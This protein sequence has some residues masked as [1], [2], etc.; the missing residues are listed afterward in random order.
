MLSRCF[1]FESW[2]STGVL[3]YTDAA[4]ISS[5]AMNAV[6]VMTERGYLSW[7]GTEFQPNK[8][9]TRAEIMATLDGAI[10][11]I[12]TSNGFYSTVVEGSAL[13]RASK[14]YLMNCNI[15]GNVIIP[16]NAE[17]VVVEELHPELVPGLNRGV[18]TERFVFA[19]KVRDSGRNDEHFVS[20]DAAPLNAREELLRQN[21]D[22]RRRQLRAD[23][24]LLVR[25]ENVDDTV[26]RPLRPGGVERAE[27][28]VPRFGGG[29][30][31]FDRF[32]VAHFPDEDDVR[33][34]TQ[35]AADRVGEGHNVDADFALVDGRLFMIVVE[36]DR[37]FDRDDVVVDVRVQPVDASGERRR[38]PGTGRAGN[39]NHAARTL[40]QLFHDGR[41]P[42]LLHR[43][44][45]VRN[46][47]QNHPGVP[48]L[49]EDG[50]AETGF[51]A[52]RE[53]EVGAA[54][55][56]QFLLAAARRDTFHQRNGVGRLERFRFQ[57]HHAPVQTKHRRLTDGDVQVGRAANDDGF[58]EFVD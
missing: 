26:D 38:L 37:V 19:D 12:W 35:R 30:R 13:I 42:E 22:N 33:V 16:G 54:A 5:W 32:Q 45:V 41:R 11:K 50:N 53:P 40:N 14:V 52:E 4:N 3:P 48:L 9:I 1:G 7:A 55:L 21:A 34:L 31:G 25:R 58:E 10:T 28:D 49:F 51:V 6:S 29:N 36:F 44:H 56:L 43:E 17:D 23:L 39:Q 20:G 15:G 46:L 18:N 27:D 47:T 57:A 2:S 8:P 24:L